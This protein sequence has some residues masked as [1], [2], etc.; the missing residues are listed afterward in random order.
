MIPPGL[1]RV[2]LVK[3]ISFIISKDSKKEIPVSEAPTTTIRV[4]FSIFKVLRFRL[5]IIDKEN[6]AYSSSNGSLSRSIPPLL[7]RYLSLSSFS[8]LKFHFFLRKCG[9]I[10]ILSGVNSWKISG[11]R[12]LLWTSK[13]RHVLLV[14]LMISLSTKRTFLM[15]SGLMNEYI[16]LPCLSRGC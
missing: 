1:S 12:V 4:L 5:V 9:K 16:T 7:V 3:L 14:N 10:L 11:R 2:I 13:Y 15:K 8:K 6:G